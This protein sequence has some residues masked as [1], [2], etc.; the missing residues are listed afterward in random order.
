MSAENVGSIAAH[1]SE[2][3]RMKQTGQPSNVW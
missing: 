1:D 3:S 2:G